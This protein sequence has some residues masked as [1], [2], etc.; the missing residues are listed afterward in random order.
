[1]T[2]KKNVV[3]YT[4]THCLAS[5]LHAP[6]LMQLLC[7]HAPVLMQL[8]CPQVFHD[9][10][11]DVEGGS[12]KEITRAMLGKACAVMGGVYLFYLFEL[13][14]RKLTSYGTQEAAVSA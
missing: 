11:E 1:M 5:R 2:T 7:P 14:L 8:L 10:I 9:A 13:T 3:D 6:V 12:E 4:Q